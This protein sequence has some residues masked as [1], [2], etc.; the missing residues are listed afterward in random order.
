ML[1]ECEV[2]AFEVLLWEDKDCKRW[3]EEKRLRGKGGKELVD[4]CRILVHER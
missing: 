1:A 2:W 3:G 4:K